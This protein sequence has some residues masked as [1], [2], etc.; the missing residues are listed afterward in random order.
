MSALIFD[1]ET[2]GKCDFKLPPSHPSQPRIVQLAAQLIDEDWKIRGEL[3]LIIRPDGWTIPEEVAK[4]HGITTAIAMR[5][6]VPIELALEA[7]FKLYAFESHED[8]PVYVAHNLDFD[9]LLIA[10]EKYR[11]GASGDGSQIRRY[12]QSSGFCTMKAMTPICRLPGSY[13]FK[14]PQLQEAHQH[15]FGSG[16]D[17]AHD[18]M[19]DV[20]AC[21][22][23][24]R[25]LKE[26][27]KQTV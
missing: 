3:N 20:R 12:I 11:L 1:T 6:G 9:S 18:A 7:F 24:Y 25:W 2:N 16:F 14:W 8:E 22:A 10:S 13:G 26:G 21:G 15:C 5:Y 17:G 19:A 27:N 4:I 23:V